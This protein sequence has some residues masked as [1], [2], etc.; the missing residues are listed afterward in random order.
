MS[1]SPD[2]ADAEEYRGVTRKLRVLLG[3]KLWNEHLLWF[4][5]D[6]DEVRPEDRAEFERIDALRRQLDEAIA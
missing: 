4:P 5:V 2:N 1:G 6:P 3:L